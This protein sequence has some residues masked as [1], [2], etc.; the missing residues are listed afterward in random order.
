MALAPVTASACG[1]GDRP[2]DDDARAEVEQQFGRRDDAAQQPESAPAGD[3]DTPAAIGPD[4]DRARAGAGRTGGAPEATGAGSS[5]AEGTSGGPPV[6]PAAVPGA[7]DSVPAVPP[8]GGAQQPDPQTILAAADTAYRFMPSLRAGF[9]QRME[10]PLLDRVNEGVGSWYQVGRDRFRMDFSDP[11]DDQF[12]ADGR[13]LWLYQPSSQPHQVLRC[14]LAGGAA[15]AGTADLLGRILSE[16]RT[17]YDATYEGSETV[18]GV[19]T[20]LISMTPRGP[21]DYRRVRIWVGD[22]DRLVRRFRIDH[23]NENIRTVTLSDLEPGVP[24][25]DS[26]FRFSPPAGVETFEC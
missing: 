4:H 26:L 6:D 1:G 17:A 16:A 8:P 2:V 3:V 5:G 22:R 11:P 19:S 12:V 20:H 23:E 21:S 10:V 15:E 9:S 25:P 14:E 24:L 13:F 18:S 7:E